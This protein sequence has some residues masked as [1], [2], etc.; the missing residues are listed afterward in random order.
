M[1]AKLLHSCPALCDLWTVASQLLCPWD[2]PGKNT[3]EGLPFSSP[4]DLPKPRIKPASL[5]FPAL[6]GRFITTSAT[7]E[8]Q[9]KPTHPQISKS[10]GCSHLW[11]TLSDHVCPSGVHHPY[12]GQD[13]HSG[14]QMELSG[15]MY[16]QVVK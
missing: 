16:G 14:N 10:S 12:E 4:G 1:H 5:M 9:E 3:G 6:A 11:P 8:A 15:A 13:S 7:W 2:S